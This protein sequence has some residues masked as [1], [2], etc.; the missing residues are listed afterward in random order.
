M[1]TP[2]VEVKN[3]KV[4]FPV[5]RGTLLHR[6]KGMC[7]AVDGVDF[8]LY[9]GQTLGLVGES[10]CGKS[11]TARAVTQLLR[12]TEGEVLFEGKDLTKLKPE[13]LRKERRHFQMIFQDPFA[14]LNPRMTVGDIVAEPL[15]TFDVVR[16]K[17][18]QQEVQNLL[19]LVGL[20]PRYVR[21]YPHEFSGGQRQRIGIAR[22]LAL[23]PKLIV[24]DEPV[25]ALDVSIQA[26]ILNLLLDLKQKFQL[27]YLFIAH[28]LA[29][30]R[31]VSDQIAVM[32]LGK[33]VEIASYNDIY[34]N[35]KHPYTQA[36]LA[37]SPIPDPKIEKERQRQRSVLSGDLPSPLNPPPGCTFH[38][39][40][41]HVMMHCKSSV[42]SL[43]EYSSG[44]K[45][46]CHLLD[47]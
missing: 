27:T 22:A 10:G 24:A 15:K 1:N 31:H 17:P 21:R 8:T 26:Q 35:P 33:I 43:K 18:L 5:S 30:V 12:P 9:K 41:P 40:C 20:D 44:H 4:H 36:L 32:Y 16:G 6:E 11:T 42:P 38:T 23:K 19:R 13:A 14:S 25:S 47:K 37:S 34:E 28:D 39:R 2:L 29:V 45:T 3:L 46:A 7:L